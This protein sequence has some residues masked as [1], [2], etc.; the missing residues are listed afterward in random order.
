MPDHTDDP[1]MIAPVTPPVQFDQ[2]ELAFDPEIER[3]IW[4]AQARKAFSVSGAGLTVA[5]CDT[6]LNVGHVDFA[7][8]VVAT[9]NF[10]TDDG[11]DPTNATDRNGHG[12]NVTGLIAA[13]ADHTG[14]APEVNI[15]PIKV[16]ADNGSGS[17]Q[18]IEDALNWVNDNHEEHTITAVCMSLGDGGNYTDDDFGPGFRADL[19]KII[20]KLAEKRIA[21]CIAAGN[22]F[23]SHNSEE[24][25]GFPAIIRECISV[26][27][28]Y[29]AEEGGFSYFSGAEATSSKP[30][31]ITPFSQRL[32]W[33]TNRATYTDIFAPGA[34]ATS[35]GIGTD[36]N[37]PNP[38]GESTQHGTSQATPV[39]TGVVLLLQEYYQRM[40][41]ELPT[42]RQL[43]SWLRSG[44]VS[45]Y[46][47]DDEA[48]NVINTEKYYKRVDAL[49][50]LD[51]ARRYLQRKRLR[52]SVRDANNA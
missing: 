2:P 52:E 42:I 28:V 27:A 29:D 45:I 9:R 36:P 43:T 34:P 5:V 26:G 32:H 51:A 6:G 16:L 50:A 35:S 40:T 44:G 14:I 4:A 20:D 37:N 30:G 33:R 10:T 12:T 24:G 25:M 31:Q 17:F 7:G 21:V 46:D 39:T 48:D 1:L 23:F 8:R 49:S 11:G 13:N 47:G 3:F 41:G 18:W 15:I 19:R 38:H 22:D